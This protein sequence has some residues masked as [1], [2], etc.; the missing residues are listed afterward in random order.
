MLKQNRGY[1]VFKHGNR[2]DGVRVQGLA[3]LPPLQAVVHGIIQ[4][5]AALLPLHLRTTQAILPLTQRE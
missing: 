1:E 5:E 3:G 2:I 4:G